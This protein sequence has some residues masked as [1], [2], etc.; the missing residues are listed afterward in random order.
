MPLVE[1]TELVR[2]KVVVEGAE[3]WLAE[4]PDLV[5]GLER[6][7][8]MTIHRTYAGGSEAFVA[9]VTLEDGTEGV[10]KLLIPRDNDWARHEI[11]VLT[12]AEG[13]GCAR[14]M[15][16]DVARSAM[17]L[18]RLGPTLNEFGLPIAR[19]HE[20]LV[21][22]AQRLWRPAPGCGLPTG[23][24]KGRWLIDYITTTW[25]HLGRPCSEEA[26]EYAL[27]C[28]SR[29]IAAHDDE[30][31]VLVHGDIHEWNTLQAG[32]GWK[33]I[34]PD[35]LLA[36]PEY[37]LGVIMREDPVELAE[38]DPHTRSRWLAAR[39]GLD[40]AAIWEWGTVERLSTGLVLLGIDLQPVGSQMLATA[41]YVARIARSSA[42]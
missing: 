1:V 32:D 20:I 2:N 22:T 31:A 18:E 10:L 14:L 29:R 4:L 12:L 11:T 17:L 30:R 5:A 39:T 23:A 34:D 25:E 38:G 15:R 8:G 42:G 37:D 21:S 26:V 13:N 24:E 3:H 19:R 7:W 28:A 40:E 9:G 36:E 35:G 41:E 27:E 6:E 33:L 16:S